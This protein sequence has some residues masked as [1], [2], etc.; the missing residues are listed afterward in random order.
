MALK[1]NRRVFKRGQVQFTVTAARGS[2]SRGRTVAMN[3]STNRSMMSTK[4][5]FSG[6]SGG[7]VQ[8]GVGVFFQQES[9]GNVY[10]KTIVSGG[11]AERDGTCQVGDMIVGECSCG[12]RFARAV[13]TGLRV[14]LFPLRPGRL[15][16]TRATYAFV[17]VDDREV[18]GQPLAALRGL[19]LGFQGTSGMS[20]ARCLSRCCQHHN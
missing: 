13:C 5:M 7:S 15:V 12:L 8:A 17:A 18:L 6:E 1:F 3:A 19:I 14:T 4:D 16:L 10:I 11:A 9:D 20:A 2:A